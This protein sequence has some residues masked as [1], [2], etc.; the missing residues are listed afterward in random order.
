M[1][2]LYEKIELKGL[3]DKP[4]LL[5]AYIPDNTRELDENRRHISVLVCPGGGYS[6]C[7]E[8]EA[9]PIALKLAAEGI[10]AFVLNYHC[11]PDRFPAPMQDAA[12]AMGYIRAHA[13]KYHALP[14]R[15]AIMGFSAGGHL[16]G[17][18]GVLWNKE[19]LWKPLGL[20]PGMVRPDAMVLCY[21]VLTAGDQA[22][23]DS[24]VNLTGSANPA[25]HQFLSLEKLVDAQTP[26][27][28]LWH[29]AEDG[30]VPVQNSLLFAEA[31]SENGVLCEMHI[32]PKG[33]HGLS[34]GNSVT[35]FD[36]HEAAHY[37]S[38]WFAHAVHFLQ[39]MLPV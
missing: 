22:H 19:E 32:Y 2:V 14:D 17:S 38:D 5:C 9:E 16:A 12:L 35:A 8:R 1:T 10:N 24:F 36:P 13:D 28:F 21:P 37:S 23:R 7:S 3:C 26:P 15:V 25:D 39:D 27:A 6:W 11:A 18:M 34:L 29:T 30:L 4:A 33:G 31:L 20:T